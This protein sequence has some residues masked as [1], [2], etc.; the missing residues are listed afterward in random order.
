MRARHLLI[1]AT[2]NGPV[3][4]APPWSP[5]QA[6]VPANAPDVLRH[7]NMP[8]SKLGSSRKGIAGRAWACVHPGA[9]FLPG[10]VTLA[11]TPGRIVGSTASLQYE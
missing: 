4:N 1:A 5:G 2:I 8:V 7:D 9:P 11:N 3:A 10:I 6:S